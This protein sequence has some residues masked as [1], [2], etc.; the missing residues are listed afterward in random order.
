[1]SA[2]PFRVAGHALGSVSLPVRR[3]STIVGNCQ[4]R[5][6]IRQLEKNNVVGEV[7]HR[8]ASHR[9]VRHT[10]NWSTG[11]R[12]LLDQLERPLHFIR[13]ATTDI[14][15]PFGVP[16]CR[17]REVTLR[18]GSKANCFNASALRGERPR[19]QRANRLRPR[20]SRA[21]QWRGVLF[22]VP[23]LVLHRLQFRRDSR[24]VPQRV[25]LVPPAQV[26][27]RLRVAVSRLSSQPH[28]SIRL[29]NSRSSCLP[30][31]PVPR[32]A[33]NDSVRFEKCPK[34]SARSVRTIVRTRAR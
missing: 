23:T 3:S 29:P 6:S 17:G 19:G 33:R 14:S 15:V 20:C 34:S 24:A 18:D 32:Y 21:H 31:A 2:M 1:M 28:P 5:D 9:S 25:A 27:A 13:E 22:R 11:P 30:P 7:V 10:G 26:A 12:K 8:Q 4:D 16:G